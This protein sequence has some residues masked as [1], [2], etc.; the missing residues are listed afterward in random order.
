MNFQIKIAK[1][2][3]ITLLRQDL[4]SFFKINIFLPQRIIIFPPSVLGG[5]YKYLSLKLVAVKR[6][7]QTRVHLIIF[8][9][10]AILDII[11]TDDVIILVNLDTNE[12]QGVITS[13]H[14]CVSMIKTT[15]EEKVKNQRFCLRKF[16]EQEWANFFCKR[17]EKKCFRL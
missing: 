15:A 13:L 9:I 17:P 16:Q 7:F 12:Q 11:H 6:L 5:Q 3:W 2:D 1:K 8:D 14:V 4:F 10:K